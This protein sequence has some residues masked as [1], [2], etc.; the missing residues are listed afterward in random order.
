MECD[1]RPHYILVDSAIDVRDC[2]VQLPSSYRDRN[3]KRIGATSRAQGQ[4]TFGSKQAISSSIRI[5][6]RNL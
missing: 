6:K 4:L 2:T 3:G 1:C 5:R